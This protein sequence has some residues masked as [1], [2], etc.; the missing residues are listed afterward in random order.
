[1][2]R[3]IPSRD[4]VSVDSRGHWSRTSIFPPRGGVANY[5]QTSKRPLA[6]HGLGLGDSSY[7]PNLYQ[8]TMTLGLTF[9]PIQIRQVVTLNAGH[10]RTI[11]HWCAVVHYGTRGNERP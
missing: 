10:S 11:L 9:L 3:P 6:G 7:I 8:P 5:A 1:M 4:D 2:E